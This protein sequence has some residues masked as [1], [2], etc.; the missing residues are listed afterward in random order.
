MALH[1][2]T[3]FTVTSEAMVEMPSEMSSISIDA[4]VNTAQ[5][6]PDFLSFSAR[7]FRSTLTLQD[8]YIHFSLFQERFC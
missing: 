1:L 4:N 6:Q 3:L 5:G 8:L 7:L 2:K